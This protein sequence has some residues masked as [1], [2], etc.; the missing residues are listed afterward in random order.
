VNSETWDANP[1]VLYTLTSGANHNVIPSVDMAYISGSLYAIVGW[2]D[3]TESP[4]KVYYS[5]YSEGS[6]TNGSFVVTNFPSSPS[7]Q[8][9]LNASGNAFLLFN[10]TAGTNEVSLKVTVSSNRA[11]EG[12]WPTFGSPTALIT[13]KNN[14]FT[15]LI[16]GQK[17]NMNDFAIAFWMQINSGGAS[18][19]VMGSIYDGTSWTSTTLSNSP[20]LSG[21][22]TLCVDQYIIGGAA[23]VAW[24]D[25]ADLKVQYYNSSG[26]TSSAWTTSNTSSIRNPGLYVNNQ[27]A[28]IMYPTNVRNGK[29]D[30]N[31]I[32]I[33]TP[34]SWDSS[35]N[36]LTTTSPS[37]FVQISG[38]AIGSYMAAWIT[39]SNDAKY[40]TS[41]DPTTVKTLTNLALSTGAIYSDLRGASIQ[42]LG[43]FPSGSEF[44]IR[45]GIYP[46]VPPAPRPP[47]GPPPSPGMGN[48]TSSG[49]SQSGGIGVKSYGQ[50]SKERLGDGTP[51]EG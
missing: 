27:T 29:I 5:T 15:P 17:V 39:G 1:T 42:T 6:W 20:S 48:G 35:S 16:G 7:A 50:T 51:A 41:A 19:N 13:G 4:Q 30:S 11:G 12:V 31:T 40:V 26:W 2:V 44:N 43:A 34:P 32:I 22:Q 38:N 10:E 3:T 45:W 23:A 21:L 49:G 28:Y 24:Y 33:G 25:N 18:R 9:C 46:D 8:V 47:P 14:I 36:I 37:N